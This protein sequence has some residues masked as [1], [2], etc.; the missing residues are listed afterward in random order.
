MTQPKTKYP[1]ESFGPELMEA[2]VRG[3][4]P[5]GLV[6][7]KFD[8]PGGR[9]HARQFQL[10]VQQLRTRMRELNHPDYPIAARAMVSMKWGE[11]AIAHGA[12]EDWR[13]D[14]YGEKGCYIVISPRDSEFNDALKAAGIELRPP[15]PKVPGHR[16]IPQG[17]LLSEIMG[18]APPDE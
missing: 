4:K 11:K 14:Y 6:V 9:K 17:D 8:K 12:P 5:G 10:R 2:I 18:D 3:G 13:E 15:T 16:T 1:I 7:L